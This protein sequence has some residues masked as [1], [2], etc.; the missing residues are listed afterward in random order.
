MHIASAVGT[1]VLALYGPI[2][3]E[4]SGPV[5]EGHRIVM[6]DELDCC[7]CNSFDCKNQSFRLCMEMITVDEVVQIAAEML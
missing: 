4:R 3:P 1:R 5:G 2:S 7:P 6:H